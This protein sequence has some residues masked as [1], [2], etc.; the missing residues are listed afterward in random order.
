M[1]DPYTLNSYSNCKGLNMLVM[2][3]DILGVQLLALSL[4]FISLHLLL[5]VKINNR[6][7]LT[8]VQYDILLDHTSV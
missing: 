4:P 1:L 8:Q 6:F 3:L 7:Y 5:V 2:H